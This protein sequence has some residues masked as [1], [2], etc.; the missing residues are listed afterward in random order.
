MKRK[1]K[2]RNVNNY[3]KEWLKAWNA[4]LDIQLAFDTYALITYIISYVGKDESGMTKHLTDC[5]KE[6]NGQPF[7][8]QLNALKLKFLTH[9]LK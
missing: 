2:E 5:L 1:I 3:N 6:Y 9:G 4:N 8:D 7:E